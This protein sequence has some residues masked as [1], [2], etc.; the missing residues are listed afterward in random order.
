MRKVEI[1]A[2]S[3]PESVSEGTLVVWHHKPGEP[4]TR[5]TPL[6]DVE[7]E[8]VV[9]EVMSQA[10]G[11][12]IEIIKQ[13]GETVL[14]GEVLGHFS[15]EQAKSVTTPTDAR[16]SVAESGDAIVLA[17]PAARQLSKEKQV[18]LNRVTGTGKDGRIT[19]EDVQ[20]AVDQDPAVAKPASVAAPLVTAAPA[21]PAIQGERNE[22]R[23]PMTRIRASI[24]KRLV[25]AQ[26]T[27][28]ML[29]TF[30]EVD[31]SAIMAMR[32]KYKDEF[33]EAHGG[34]RLGFMSFFVTA[35]VGALKKFPAVNASIDGSDIVYH[36]YY[37]IGIAVGTDRG[38]VVPILR[39]AE[40]LRIADIEAQ[41]RGYG[42]KAQQGKL[43]LEEMQGG[44]FTISNGGVYGSLLSTPILNAPQTAVLGMHKIQ[45]RPIAVQ[46]E[47]QIAPMM[48]LALSYDHRLIDGSEAVRFLVCIKDL[49]EDPARMLLAL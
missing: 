47:V 2:P 34:T 25:S 45:P 40:H 27:A 19:K 41:I 38:L 1:N 15:I 44:T 37:D 26:Q 24:A 23:V 39:D 29:T 21:T 9:I 16:V 33:A 8:K 17:S 18:D 42:E 46:G 35:A 43:T 22:R 20:K 3:F 11:K 6:A 31:M 36:G 14:A 7:T 48:Y 28:A 4:V 30:N 12:I 49:L 13:E 5:D 10:D 32:S